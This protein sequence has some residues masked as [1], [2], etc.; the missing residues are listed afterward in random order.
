MNMN[1][2]AVILGI[3]VSG[4]SLV[5]GLI[6]AIAWYSSKVKKEY[7]AQRDFNHLKN[8]YQ[9]LAINVENLWRL[10]DDSF[11]EH[12]EKLRQGQSDILRELA[13]LSRD[14]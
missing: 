8:N 7:A 12:E 10:M 5:T 3:L 6:G 2:V 13:K 9:Q 14:T 4:L 11:R 1:A